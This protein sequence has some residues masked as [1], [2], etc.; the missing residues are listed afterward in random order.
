MGHGLVH[1]FISIIILNFLNVLLQLFV[2]SKIK[3]LSP[4]PVFAAIFRRSAYSSYNLWYW[5]QSVSG[6]MAFLADKLVVAWF[7]DVRTLGYY[8]IASL[9]GNQINNFFIAFGAFIFPRVSYRMASR[10]DISSFY[11]VVRSFVAIPGW[12]II[13]VLLIAGDVLFRLWL[14][15][16]TFQNSIFYIRLYLVYEACMLLVIVPGNFFNGSTQIRMNSMFEMALR[17]SHIL[18]MIVGYYLFS[19]NGILYGLIVSTLLNLPYRYYLFHRILIPELRSTAF[20]EVLLP[21][22]FFVGMI[23]ST[24]LIFHLV[25]L[26]LLVLACK[27][28]YFDPARHYAKDFFIFRNFFGRLE[29]K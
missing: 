23:G 21:L 25:M 2:L 8:S 5:V 19:I 4:T 20:L 22:V 13:S 11:L 7:T 29:S 17:T 26:V 1:I 14:G 27:I 9:I 3:G 10:H 28:I 15:E 24:G 16:E 12:A 18:F 6:L